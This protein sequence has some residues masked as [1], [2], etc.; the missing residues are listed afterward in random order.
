MASR[1]LNEPSP[2][3]PHVGLGGL[4]DRRILV[5][6]A[7]WM[8]ERKLLRKHHRNTQVDSNQSGS[9][10]TTP[11]HAWHST[12]RRTLV[13]ALLRLCQRCPHRGRVLRL[14]RRRPRSTRRP[15]SDFVRHPHRYRHRV[16]C[17][18]HPKGFGELT[19]NKPIRKGSRR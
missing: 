8:H 19:L 11:V 2:V 3:N 9:R 17:R 14:R 7:L 6:H 16:D 5:V 1:R 13:S 12:H 18:R 4:P 10:V 15:G